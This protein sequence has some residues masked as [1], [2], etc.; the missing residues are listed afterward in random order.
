MKFIIILLMLIPNLT[1]AHD[2]ANELDPPH[3]DYT[4]YEKEFIVDSYAK[5]IY[6]TRELIRCIATWEVL[7]N[8]HQDK[9]RHAAHFLNLTNAMIHEDGA[10][11]QPLQPDRT[12]K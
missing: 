5:R 2:T 3:Y 7:H 1:Y 11:G 9:C 6:L 4:Q 8:N 10:F 12:P